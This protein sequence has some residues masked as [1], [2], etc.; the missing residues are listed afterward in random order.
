MYY[1]NLV[2]VTVIV[3]FTTKRGSVT[4]NLRTGLFIPSLVPMTMETVVDAGVDN[5]RTL[6]PMI[7]KLY[8]SLDSSNPELL[9]LLNIAQ[10]Q[11]T[12]VGVVVVE[13]RAENCT[14]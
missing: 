12:A 4:T 8:A 1:T 11:S 14:E 9:T 13:E 2:S 7:K 6:P 5:G 10:P 3:E